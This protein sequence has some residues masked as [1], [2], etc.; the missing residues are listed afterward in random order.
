MSYGS[1]GPLLPR[2]TSRWFSANTHRFWESSHDSSEQVGSKCQQ[3]FKLIEGHQVLSS[4]PLTCV[5]SLIVS[6]AFS[7][8]DVNADGK[9][10]PGLWGSLWMLPVTITGQEPFSPFLT[11]LAKF[12][13]V[14]PW[15]CSQVSLG[16]RGG[17]GWVAERVQ[18]GSRGV[19][20]LLIL[21]FLAMLW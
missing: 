2:P 10:M 4:W 19:G 3:G 16:C 12:P 17:E 20:G 18:G 21:W 15:L 11:R 9:V 5:W 1:V 8:G 6:A 14:L 7:A 13:A